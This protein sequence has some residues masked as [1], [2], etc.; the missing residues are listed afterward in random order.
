[1][2]EI[3]R[4]SKL[5]IVRNTIVVVTNVSF[6]PMIHR[7]CSINIAIHRQFNILL[8]PQKT[9]TNLHNVSRKWCLRESF[10]AGG[11]QPDSHTLP[12]RCTLCI[13]TSCSVA[14]FSGTPQL[15]TF[16]QNLLLKK[17]LTTLLPGVLEGCRFVSCFRE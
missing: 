16:V 7:Y 13:I 17:L 15:P 14:T 12:N 5:S 8:Q 6:S 2:L 9:N 1:M 10:P 3:Y 4:L 11:G